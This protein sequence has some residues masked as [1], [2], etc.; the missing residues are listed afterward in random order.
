MRRG[1]LV[2]AT[3]TEV[4]VEYPTAGNY[5][6]FVQFRHRGRVHTAAFTVAV[7]A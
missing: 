6:V 7:P 2:P 3:V 5:R 1:E 4:H